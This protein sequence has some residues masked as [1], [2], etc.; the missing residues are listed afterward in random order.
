MS[1]EKKTIIVYGNCQAATISSFLQTLPELSSKYDIIHHFVYMKESDREAWGEQ[2]SRAD[3][4]F[5]Q[6]LKDWSSYL[7]REEA[8]KRNLV[9][10][11]FVYF[12]ALW[13]FDATQNQPD[14]QALALKPSIPN[15]LNFDYE[16]SLLG[17]MR[18]ELPD[19][20]ERYEAY[21]NLS[22]GRKMNVR[23][24]CDA[25]IAR[26]E[27]VDEL[28]D[29]SIGRYIIE[30]FREKRIF[31]T[32]THPTIDLFA[33]ISSEICRR[34][35]IPCCARESSAV[36]W[37]SAYQVPIHPKVIEELGIKWANSN[38]RYNHHGK[39]L[40]F[41]AYYRAYIHIYG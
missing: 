30:N 23:R 20:E 25:E 22:Y 29:L 7:Y 4:V 2:I 19:P 17:K 18:S 40:T 41:E 12:A 1:A 14:H 35:G 3:F 24:Y 15:H 28:F 32:V 33:N 10:F 27:K 6:D 31:H 13:P 26:L 38:T 16:D 9:R 5:S 8:E 21:L 34:A 36:D 39:E 11:P 37:M